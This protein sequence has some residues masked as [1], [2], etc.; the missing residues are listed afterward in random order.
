[1]WTG[2]AG[3]RLDTFA[4]LM[5]LPPLAVWS[6]AE[7]LVK[8]VNT[9]GGKLIG[10][11]GWRSLPGLLS[12]FHP[13]F[14]LFLLLISTS[15][16]FSFSSLYIYLFSSLSILSLSL[17][18][19]S[20]PA[21]SFLSSLLPCLTPFLSSSK[22]SHITLSSSSPFSTSTCPSLLDA[23]FLFPLLFSFSPFSSFLSPSLLFLSSSSSFL[24]N[25]PPS[26]FYLPF[27]SPPL[28]TPYL[29][30]NFSSFRPSLWSF[31]AGPQRVS[32]TNVKVCHW[33]SEW[34]MKLHDW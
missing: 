4:E 26:L 3:C 32:P 33:M 2:G 17:L 25:N 29:L 10:C 9:W 28:I 31:L 23:D 22:L 8:L 30:Q 11:R 19:S 13:S 7:W 34:M 27:F 12:S 16:P 14:P 20:S 18:S 21:L 1:M 24:P 15:E 6:Q 5:S